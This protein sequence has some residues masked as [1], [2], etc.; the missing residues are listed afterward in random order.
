MMCNESVLLMEDVVKQEF[1]F[2]LMSQSVNQKIKPV[3][4]C[5]CQPL[6]T[7]K[8]W[9]NNLQFYILIGLRSVHFGRVLTFI[10]LHSPSALSFCRL[11]TH[12][13]SIKHSTGYR[14]TIPLHTSVQY[15]IS[16]HRCSSFCNCPLIGQY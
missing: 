3:K 14:H 9:Y 2:S 12:Q 15:E 13:P 7:I 11:W 5:C 6:S 8:Y 16:Y 10:S 1:L 4:A